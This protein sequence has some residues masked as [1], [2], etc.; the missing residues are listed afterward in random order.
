MTKLSAVGCAVLLWCSAAFAVYDVSHTPSVIDQLTTGACV[1]ANCWATQTGG[2]LKFAPTMEG[3]LWMITGSNVIKRRAFG[4]TAWVTKPGA[5]LD[6]TAATEASNQVYIVGTDHKVYKWNGSAWAL[7]GGGTLLVDKISVGIDNELFVIQTS[8]KEAFHWNGS[9][10]VDT[11]AVLND[12]SA[13]SKGHT[14]GRYGGLADSIYYYNSASNTF[15]LVAWQPNGQPPPDAYEIQAVGKVGLFVV[16]RTAAT[17]NKP[18]LY[19]ATNVTATTSSNYTRVLEP[20]TSEWIVSGSLGASPY[21]SLYLATGS[22]PTGANNHI[23]HLNHLITQLTGTMSGDYAAFCANQPN[24]CPPGSAHSLT[25]QLS[26]PGSTGAQVNR[27]P[28]APAT[29]MSA[30][31]TASFFN[32]DQIFGDPNAP[33]CRPTQTGGASCAVMG[34]LIV[35]NFPTSLPLLDCFLH[36]IPSRLVAWQSGVTVKVIIDS[37][38]FSVSF[39]NAICAGINSW[40]ALNGVNYNCTGSANIGPPPTASTP[41]PWLFVTSHSGAGGGNSACGKNGAGVSY[42]SSTCPINVWQVQTSVI[43]V[44]TISTETGGAITPLEWQR[45]A[46]HEEGHNNWLDNC[47]NCVVETNGINESAMGPGDSEGTEE[48]LEPT[49]CDSIYYAALQSDSRTLGA[50]P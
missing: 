20:V 32:C 44:G 25:Y 10:F 22:D 34:A 27:G 40:H 24:A 16:S 4:S 12:I 15:S 13:G 14:Y 29:F 23:Y 9:S 11:G 36:P 41:K 50:E 21:G 19:Y 18:V 46:V 3:H 33:G 5:A 7:F 1:S 35:N 8:T 37:S 6:I 39:A 48:P 2:G 31:S 43:D 42:G 47:L 17:G 26:V 38:W 30:S 45:V 49:T 28:V